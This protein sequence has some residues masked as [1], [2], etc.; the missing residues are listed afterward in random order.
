MICV[1]IVDVYL[2]RYRGRTGLGAHCRNWQVLEPDRL[3]K[4][5]SCGVVLSDQTPLLV[6]G[7]RVTAADRLGNALPRAFTS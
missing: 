7:K 1:H 6:V 5:L 3:L 2:H 4:E